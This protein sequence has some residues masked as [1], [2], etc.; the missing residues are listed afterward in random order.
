MN[1]QDFKDELDYERDW[2]LDEMVFLRDQLGNIADD[3]KKKLYRRSLLVMLYAHHEGF[4][5]FAL[6]HYV[7]GINT[8][9]LGCAAVNGAIVAAA[10]TDV[11]AALESG[12]RKNRVFK[13]QLPHDE[14]LHRFSRRRDFV[15]D[16]DRLQ[17]MTATIPDTAIDTESNL[18]PIV[19]KKNLYRVG[20]SYDAFSQHDG[21]IGM[22]LQRRNNIAHGAQRDGID[23]A[24]YDL[25]EAAVRQIMTDLSDMLVDA[26]KKQLF[27]KPTKERIESRAR[28]IW[29]EEGR[30]S[31][32]DVAIWLRAEAELTPR[33]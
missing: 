31:G 32:K 8:V 21:D 16:L 5:K 27:L 10:W 19:M 9:K 7:R 24:D 6:Q 12:D 4:C 29:E 1:V 3:D 18:W 14:P 25:L 28:E 26:V 17:R 20:L 15:N 2:R 11:F 33:G 23:Q 30:P 22:L 13:S